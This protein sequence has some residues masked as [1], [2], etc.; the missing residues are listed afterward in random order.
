MLDLTYTKNTLSL[1]KDLYNSTRLSRN[2]KCEHLQ[3]RLIYWCGDKP[4]I[5]EPHIFYFVKHILI[6]FTNLIYYKY[7]MK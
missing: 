1:F 7:K 3:V 4:F 5:H 2:K 6:S